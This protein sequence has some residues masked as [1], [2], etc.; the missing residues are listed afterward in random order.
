[1]KPEIE[2]DFRDVQIPNLALIII[3]TSTILYRF[4]RIFACGSQM[5]SLR[6]LLFE[7]QTGSSLPI[8]EVC[9]F[10]FR[11]FSGYG[12]HT[13]TDQY[14]ITCTDKIRQCRLCIQW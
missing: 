4:S 8:L 6:R 2:I 13:S 5:W 7:R 14:Q 3:I 11:K 1:M 12:H 10:Q 9:G